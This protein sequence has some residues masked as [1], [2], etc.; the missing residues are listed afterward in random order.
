[1]AE[2]TCPQCGASV[3]V[4]ATECK[5]CGETFAQYQQPV[6]QSAQQPVQNIYVNNQSA[7]SDGIDQSW[8]IKSKIAAGILALL[9]GGIGV[10]KFYLG[11]IGTGIVYLLF[12]WTFIPAIIAFV[13]GIIYLTSNDH[14]FQVKNHVR[15]Q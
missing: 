4:N 14:N 11:K 7:T 5:Y 12:S 3:P 15:L 8:P 13:E 9:F 2:K 10:H 6:Q 1:M